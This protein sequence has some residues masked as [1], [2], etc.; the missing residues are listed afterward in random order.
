M[1]VKELF[2]R[3]WI[4]SHV[5]VP[6]LFSSGRKVLYCSMLLDEFGSFCRYRKALYFWSLGISLY[7]ELFCSLSFI[8]FVLRNL[9]SGTHRRNHEFGTSCCFPEG[10]KSSICIVRCRLTSLE[11]RAVFLAEESLL[12]ESFVAARRVW[13]VVPFSSGRKDFVLFIIAQLDVLFDFQ[14]LDEFGTSCCFLKGKYS[15]ICIVYRRSAN[16]ERRAVFF[17]EEID[18]CSPLTARLNVVLISRHSTS[19]NVVL[20]SSERKEFDCESSLN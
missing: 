2:A 13:N 7:L 6:V 8:S 1:T 10:G 19:W 15:S 18:L 11:C 16:L 17:K 5:E 4:A 20:F 12:F 14:L 9:C 3:I